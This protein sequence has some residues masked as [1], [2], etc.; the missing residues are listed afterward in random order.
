MH[1]IAAKSIENMT[2]PER[3]PEQ[4]KD[5][6][7]LPKENF[8][9]YKQIL[10][11]VPDDYLIEWHD[12]IER[13]NGF[14]EVVTD[15]ELLTTEEGSDI[16]MLTGKRPVKQ[17]TFVSQDGQKADIL[18]LLPEGVHILER[19]LPMIGAAALFDPETRTIQYPRESFIDKENYG[20]SYKREGALFTLLHEIGH[21]RSMTPEKTESWKALEDALIDASDDTQLDHYV[22]MV[23]EEERNA[24]AYAL[25]QLR[26]LR[27]QG[28][29]L[30]PELRTFKDMHNF[31]HNSLEH[32]PALARRAIR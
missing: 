30:A 2:S 32:Y 3:Q 15:P 24:N 6:P 10:A 1:C 31:I 8:K 20:S 23:V 28:I 22:A 7:H 16:E 25:R 29:D 19:L 13:P 9:P 17:L 11:E 4:T 12:I 5:L 18:S 14:V 21:S 27:T 26:E